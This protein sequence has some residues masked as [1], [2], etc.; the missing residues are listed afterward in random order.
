MTDHDDMHDMQD[1]HDTQY[2]THDSPGVPI[3]SWTRGVPIEDA[4]LC[5]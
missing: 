2:E 5:S 1:M 3:K 4:A